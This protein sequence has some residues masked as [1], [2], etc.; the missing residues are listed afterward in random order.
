MLFLAALL[1]SM[2]VAQAQTAGEL[3]YQGDG[4]PSK[5]GQSTND[6]LFIKG[7]VNFNSGE[8]QIVWFYLDDDEIY[9]NTKVQSLTPIPYNAAGDLYN[10]ITYNSFQCDIYLPTDVD[11]ISFVD[12]EGDEY[13]FIHGDRMPNATSINW[14]R[15]SA[16]TKVIDGLTYQ[17]Y[18]LVC[19][20]T[21]EYG[22]HL[23]AKT[24]KKYKDNGALK[25]DA[26]LFALYLKNKNQSQRVERMSHDLIIANQMFNLRESALAGWD[27]NNSMF[28]YGTGGNNQSQQFLKYYRAP[29]YGSAGY[30]TNGFALR[31]TSAMHGATITIPLYMEN[32]DA[33][34]AFQTDLCLPDGFSVAKA[35]GDYQIT[36]SNRKA[37]DHI[38][39]ANDIGNGV[40]RILSYSPTLKPY[41]GNSGVLLYVTITIP[42]NGDGLYP[43]S[44]KNTLLTNVNEEEKAANDVSCSLKVYPY[45]LG[46]ANNSGSVTISDVVATARYILKLNPT[47]FVFGAAD[48]NM[49]GNISITD[50]VKISRMVLEARSPR[51]TAGSG[52]QMAAMDDLGADV[53][54]ERGQ[55]NVKLDDAGRYTA[56]Q[57]DLALPAGLA[58]DNFALACNKGDYTMETYD[59]GD[60]RIRV[61][62]YSA[63]VNAVETSEGVLL[64]FSTV[65]NGEGLIGDIVV[66]GIE[67]VTVDGETRNLD[68]FSIPMSGSTAVSG[69]HAAALRV[70]QLGQD[71]MI[72]SPEARQVTVS[73][74]TGRTR[75]V[76]IHEGTNRIHIG[77][78]GVYIVYIDGK[79][80]KFML[81]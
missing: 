17:A 14:G 30:G 35:N 32:T 44:F 66:D 64:S 57:F 7:D 8:T 77:D 48:V 50:V 52:L 62:G 5:T 34:S 39:M 80:F 43:I 53:D 55:V 74:I 60:N 22:S 12:E 72:D 21:S 20:N 59:L 69:I 49:D 71:I 10:E 65:D 61:M 79:T 3:A 9:R 2:T 75:Q 73:D 78:A 1:M 25:K 31:D 28:F 41:S 16:G 47:P 54:S 70:Y 15:K 76:N 63:M 68:A 18:T 58:A 37:S 45:I 40:F 4:T 11:I 29:I 81:H 33:I 6:H 13:S 51:Y 67:L 23:S 27:A 42:E 26:T 38:V 19:Y 24:A 36:L 56:F 46:D